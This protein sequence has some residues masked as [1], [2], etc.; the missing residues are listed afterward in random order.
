MVSPVGTSRLGSNVPEGLAHGGD[1]SQAEA[2][3]PL[4]QRPFLD[5]S[6]GINPDP[7]P[8]P[9]LDP[10]I[11]ARL[12]GK[13]ELWALEE[14]ARERYGISMRADLVA[15]PGTQILIEM[16]PRLRPRGKVAV[17][18][19]TYNE[20]AHAWAKNGFDVQNVTDFEALGA[21]DV[22][23]IVN[24]NNPDGRLVPVK[25]LLDLAG[26]IAINGGWLVL[27]EA[28]ADFAPPSASLARQ[29]PENAVILRSFGKTYGLAGL[30]LGFLIAAPAIARAMRAALGPWAVSGP[31]LAIGRQALGDA[32]W[33]TKARSALNARIAPIDAALARLGADPAGTPL[34][35]F[36]EFPEAPSLFEALGARGIFIRRFAER[37][38]ALR[39]G[40]PGEADL[41]RLLAALAQVRSP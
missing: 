15:A 11:F 21:Q 30:R 12:P 16:L 5:L 13:A 23:I 41:P 32:A 8:L 9:P 36:G 18:G 10:A 25:D 38:Q 35:R 19:P 1:L 22:A 31:A 3:F 2:L 24:P 39:L 27:D 28:F 14:A 33:L 26:R 37:P 7:Y 29:W 34:F 40:I 4:A 20:H 17:L 6:T